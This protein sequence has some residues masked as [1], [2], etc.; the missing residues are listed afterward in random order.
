[1]PEAENAGPTQPRVT[2]PP[3]VEAR[4]APHPTPGESSLRFARRQVVGADPD[5]R[6]TA[7]ANEQLP[8]DV[9]V[10]CWQ[11]QAWGE[12][13]RRLGQEDPESSV[14][15]FAGIADLY[16]AD[17]HLA[18]WVCELLADFETAP[19]DA[20]TADALL[21]FAHEIRHF[22]PTGSNEAATEC[23]ALQRIADTASALGATPER[24][25]RLAR[26]A[27]EEVY[28]ANIPQYRS[29]ECRPGGLLDREPTTPAFP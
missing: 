20:E 1:M 15:E 12:L 16:A 2:A 24:T 17:V 6:L 4:S 28:P 13:N 23:A 10:W 11:E 7:V 14:V 26:I 9:K 8:L 19:D 3:A 29:R 27:W 25:A 21:V 5:E 22:S 18:P